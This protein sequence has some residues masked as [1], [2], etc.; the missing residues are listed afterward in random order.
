MKQDKSHSESFSKKQE[1]CHSELFR[2]IVLI[3]ILSF[4]FLVNPIY[5]IIARPDV[6]ISKC[7]FTIVIGVLI[8]AIYIYAAVFAKKR[9][10]IVNRLIAR[11]QFVYAKHERTDVV[12]HTSSHR[13]SHR[14]LAGYR[15][16]F[17][18]TDC[19]NNN[20]EFTESA[21]TLEELPFQP[22]DFAKV[23]VDLSRPRFYMVSKNDIMHHSN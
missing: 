14:I 22:G 1:K 4:I 5:C 12:Y 18:Y 23:Y 3:L 21:R 2:M 16:V 19:Y 7:I 8:L 17:S 20:L 9:E 6:S 15:A 11:N 10:R 13:H